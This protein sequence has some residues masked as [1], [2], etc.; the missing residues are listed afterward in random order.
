MLFTV[1]LYALFTSRDYDYVDD[2]EYEVMFS[3]VTF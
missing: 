2:I 1:F 3:L